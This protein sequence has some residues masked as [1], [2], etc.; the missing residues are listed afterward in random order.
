MGEKWCGAD[1]EK[2]SLREEESISLEAK[3]HL[4]KAGSSVHGWGPQRLAG[5]LRPKGV[6]PR[7][8]YLLDRLLIEIDLVL[9]LGSGLEVDL[10]E[11]QTNIATQVADDTQACIEKI[12]QRMR[13]LHVRRD[14]DDHVVPSVPEWC[15][16][17]M[18][19]FIGQLTTLDMDDLA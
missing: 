10:L 9:E 11:D 15:H 16:P 17:A 3:E 7:M 4:S 18:V 6:L 8:R 19:C 12:E 2:G 1:A 5:D 13:L 14:I